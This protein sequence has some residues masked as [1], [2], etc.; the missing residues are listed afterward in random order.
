MARGWGQLRLA[1]HHAVLG[2]TQVQPMGTR[3]AS[4]WKVKAPGVG[5]PVASREQGW[6]RSTNRLW[7]SGTELSAAVSRPV[8]ALMQPLHR[9]SATASFCG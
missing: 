1:V 2:R 5:V 7:C 3:M 4:V 9:H 8:L 6:R